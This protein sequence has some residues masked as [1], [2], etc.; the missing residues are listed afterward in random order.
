[1]RGIGWD[2]HPAGNAYLS[3]EKYNS[4]LGKPGD[5]TLPNITS[6]LTDGQWHRIELA[7]PLNPSMYYD[8]NG[9][10]AQVRVVVDY[11][12]SPVSDTTSILLDGWEVQ[13]FDTGKACNLATSEDYV[14]VTDGVLH[15]VGDAYFEAHFPQTNGWYWERAGTG[16]VQMLING[17]WVA[18]PAEGVPCRWNASAIRLFGGVY[19]WVKVNAIP[20]LVEITSP[21]EG[22][23]LAGATL[24]EVNATDASGIQRVEF[25]VDGSL[26]YTDF[27]APFTWTWNTIGFSDGVHRLNA[28]AY[29]T[30]GAVNFHDIDVVLDNTKPAV[31][32]TGPANNS[33]VTGS[34]SVTAVASDA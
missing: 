27:A 2:N 3:I 17:S 8:W 32:I 10:G 13:S 28:T 31:S 7:L 24:V 15:V 22:G 6:L 16:S 14:N 12:S 4:P 21:L 26:R 33:L 5:M 30:S 25:A 9:Y 20:P 19:D 1:V 29:A 23:L 11:S 18:P 34:V